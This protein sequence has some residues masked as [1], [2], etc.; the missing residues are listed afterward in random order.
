MKRLSILL[1]V[2]ADSLISPSTHSAW[3]VCSTS[4]YYHYFSFAMISFTCFRAVVV[5]VVI[6]I[7]LLERDQGKR[8]FTRN[9]VS[10]N[11][12]GVTHTD[13]NGESVGVLKR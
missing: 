10:R 4:S 12:A 8:L 1:L 11:C 13:E 2:L 3:L 9:R 6:F 7:L 5:V